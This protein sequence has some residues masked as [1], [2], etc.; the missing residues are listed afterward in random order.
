L[1]YQFLTGDNNKVKGN[2]TGMKGIQG[3]TAQAKGGSFLV[4]PK[5]FSL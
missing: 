5:S 2:L 1:K 3:I 4:K